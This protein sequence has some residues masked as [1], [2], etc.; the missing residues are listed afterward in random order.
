MKYFFQE[1]FYTKSANFQLARDKFPQQIYH[2]HRRAYAAIKR[3]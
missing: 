3:V 1:I 2:A